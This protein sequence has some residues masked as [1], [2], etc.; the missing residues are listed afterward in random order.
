M[1]NKT[2]LAA[3]LS[4][5]NSPLS[6]THSTTNPTTFSTFPFKNSHNF[7]FNLPP[8]NPQQN[9]ESST[10]PSLATS[11]ISNTRFIATL[12]WKSKSTLTHDVDL[13]AIL[14]NKY[15]V[16]H[17]VCFFNNLDQV[18]G[19]KHS[20]DDRNGFKNLDSNRMYVFFLC[21]FRY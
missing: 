12:Q 6:I 2:K 3:A 14:L 16:I 5:P 10:S 8:I 13:V 17:D 15:G 9:T 11:N 19:L 4:P 18:K 20:G 7:V 1:L 21:L